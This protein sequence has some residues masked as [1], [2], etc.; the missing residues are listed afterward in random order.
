MPAPSDITALTERGQ[1]SV[2]ARLRRELHLAQGQRFLWE[3]VSEH[4]LRLRLIQEP[5]AQ[6]ARQM[7][8]FARRFRPQTR[9]TADWMRELRAGEDE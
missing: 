6:G 1:L 3:K 4:E 9:T 5:A 2:P 7:L 8:G